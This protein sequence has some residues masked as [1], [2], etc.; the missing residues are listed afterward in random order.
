[1]QLERGRV[2]KPRQAFFRHLA[3]AGETFVRF[4]CVK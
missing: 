2:R 1:M 4:R 3:Y